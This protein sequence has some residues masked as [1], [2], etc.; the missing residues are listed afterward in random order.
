MRIA[1]A[2]LALA[3]A[4]ASLGLTTIPAFAEGGQQVMIRYSDLN[5]AAPVGRAALDSRIRGAARRVCGV[6]PA[7]QV[8]EAQQVRDCQHSAVSGAW[9][10][11]T[12][13]ASSG[14]IRATR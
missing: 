12:A 4:T 5:L 1:A 10:Q 13:T 11:I 7:V 8:E 3:T 6:V 9:N 2:I 14:R